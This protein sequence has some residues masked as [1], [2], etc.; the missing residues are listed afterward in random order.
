MVRKG[1]FKLFSY[2][3]DDYIIFYKSSNKIKKYIAFS[4]LI[5]E[6]YNSLIPVLN[7][8][9]IQRFLNYYTIQI[10]I[11]SRNKKVIL[12]NIED[13]KK[14][15]I[16]KFFNLIYQ[17]LI[18]SR[19]KIDFL[20]K[21][22]LE[23]TFLNIVFKNFS[24]NIIGSQVSETLLL[25]DEETSRYIDIY[26]INLSNIKEKHTFF[27]NFINL[28]TKLNR[29]GYLIINFRRDSEDNIRFST[30]FI[31]VRKEF[32]NTI[33]LEAEINDF[34]NYNIIKKKKIEFNK[35][36]FFLW[37]FGSA[38]YFYEIKNFT[39]LFLGSKNFSDF[40][41][42]TKFNIKFEHNL[43]NKQIKF[44]RLNQ[45]L[46]FINQHI[47]FYTAPNLDYKVILRILKKYYSKYF[48]YFL[49]LNEFEYSKLLEINGITMLDNVKL[50]SLNHFSDFNFKVFKNNHLLK[51]TQIDSDILSGVIR[52]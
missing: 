2:I 20:S 11:N 16:L 48:L 35:I 12:L 27:L 26:D 43:V 49:I 52:M 25:K 4:I 6:E 28:L 5:C 32:N 22:Q 37:R 15:R 42:M 30:S 47:L 29:N 41:N 8:F 10:N 36:F 3:V 24:S 1:K 39:D 9:L 50:L 40:K 23:T 46:F 13:K 31:D 18:K 14:D 7:K 45:N 17:E 34:F 44:K 51:N 21:D 38:D 33:K 19:I